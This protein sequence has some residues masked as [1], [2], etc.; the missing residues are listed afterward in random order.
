MPGVWVVSAFLLGVNYY[1]E[2]AAAGNYNKK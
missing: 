1:V 2:K